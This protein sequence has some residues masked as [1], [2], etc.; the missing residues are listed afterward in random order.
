MVP[1]DL[2]LS[3]AVVVTNT[4]ANKTEKVLNGICK[5]ILAAKPTVDDILSKLQKAISLTDD[6][7]QR[8]INAKESTY[9][10]K[11]EK[12]FDERHLKWIKNLYKNNK[13]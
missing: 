2:A 11:Y 1:I 6:L 9:C 5:N 3:G 13:D 4:Y 7:D 8:Y 10:D 12:M